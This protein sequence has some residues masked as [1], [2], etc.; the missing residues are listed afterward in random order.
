[1]D[2][3]LVEIY[4][5]LNDEQLISFEEVVGMLIRFGISRDDAIIQVLNQIKKVRDKSK[6]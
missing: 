5:S 6:S 3:E 1:M 2:K 4:N